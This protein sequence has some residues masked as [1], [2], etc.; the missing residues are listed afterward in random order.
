MRQIAKKMQKGVNLDLGA[1]FLRIFM[2][3]DDPPKTAKVEALVGHFE[4]LSC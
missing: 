4:N 3:K 2:S 1:F